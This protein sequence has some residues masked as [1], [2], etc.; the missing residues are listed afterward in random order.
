MEELT[1]YGFMVLTSTNFALCTGTCEARSATL[2]LFDETYMLGRIS[3]CTEVVC[4]GKSGVYQQQT[5]LECKGK[6]RPGEADRLCSGVMP[7]V[8]ALA[9]DLLLLFT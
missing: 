3:W 4:C 9:S 2:E 8:I 6:N 1:Q 5:S 7:L